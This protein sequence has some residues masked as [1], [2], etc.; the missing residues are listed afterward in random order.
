KFAS[1]TIAGLHFI[2]DQQHAALT[3]EVLHALEIRRTARTHAAFTLDNFQQHRGGV[4]SER[5]FERLEP[6]V[7]YMPEARRQ[8][9]NMLPV[10]L[11]PGRRQRTKRAAMVA[12]RG[13][14]NVG[15]SGAHAGK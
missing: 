4:V 8:G 14:D 11:V 9:A 13:G 3:A 10:A 2:D 6:I 1:A 12:T 7:G 5:R 15:F